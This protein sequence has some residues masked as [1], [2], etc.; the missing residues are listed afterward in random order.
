MAWTYRPADATGPRGLFRR[1]ASSSDIVADD[2]AE[3]CLRGAARP[4]P[5]RPRPRRRAR[6]ERPSAT[7]RTASA[8]RRPTSTRGPGTIARGASSWRSSGAASDRRERRPPPRD[9]AAAVAPPD[10]P[11]RAA[12]TGSP[13]VHRGVVGLR[14]CPPRRSAT[15][16]RP[17]PRRLRRPRASSARRSRTSGR[18]ST[19]LRDAWRTRFDAVAARHGD[20]D[21]SDEASRPIDRAIDEIGRIEDPHR[22]IDWLSTFPQVVLSRSGSG[23]EVPGRRARRPGR[24]LCRHPGRSAGRPRR[25]RCSPTRRPPQRL[26]ARAVMNGETTDPDGWR[27]MFPTLFGPSRDGRRRPSS[28][29]REAILE[30]SLAV[31][32]RGEQ[33][34]SQVRGAL[35]EELSRR[36]C[37]RAGSAPDAVRRERRILF[38]GV[39]GR[40]PPVRRDGRARRRGRGV[41]LQVGCARHQRRR[42][43]PARRRADARRRRGRAAG[44]RASSCSM[45]GGRA[46]SGSPGRPRRTRGPRSSPSRRS[47][48][49]ARG[50]R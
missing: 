27:T 45:P 41:R 39:R 35:V 30:A 1:D 24:R 28:P 36:S 44:G 16:D 7:S 11:Q 8:P 2:G 43:P 34:R 9:R 15:L 26:L 31:A 12:V 6:G 21:A 33:V 13:P 47:T 20:D 3:L 5:G 18:T 4:L 22:A 10:D 40:D 32:D 23:R 50:S 19:D 42:P 29:A 49:L 17:R 37:S 48:T 46:T 38:D 25:R 14:P